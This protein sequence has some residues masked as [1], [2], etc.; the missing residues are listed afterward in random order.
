MR[1]TSGLPPNDIRNGGKRVRHTKEYFGLWFY[2]LF[3]RGCT[4]RSL[5]VLLSLSTALQ[6]TPAY[7][8][9]WGDDREILHLEIADLHIISWRK[10][11]VIGRRHG[12]HNTEQRLS[13]PFNGKQHLQVA[14]KGKEPFLYWKNGPI[15]NIL[16]CVEAPGIDK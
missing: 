16:R 11:Y 12:R 1:K 7:H 8:R 14:G 3:D 9:R 2:F 10:G 6:K 13:L 4:C 5:S 15:G